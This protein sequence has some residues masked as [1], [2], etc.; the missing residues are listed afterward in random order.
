M[1]QVIGVSLEVKEDCVWALGPLG[2]QK[3]ASAGRWEESC[4]LEH[5][6]PDVHQLFSVGC[7]FGLT[8]TLK[9]LLH[10]STCFPN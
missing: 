6:E 9:T 7:I 5:T 2:S 1:K 4:C 10:Y 3:Q 8:T